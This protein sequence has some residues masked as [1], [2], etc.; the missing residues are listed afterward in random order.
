MRA[1]HRVV[2][3]HETIEIDPSIALTYVKLKKPGCHG[4]QVLLNG[5]CVFIDIKRSGTQATLLRYNAFD[6]DVSGAVSFMWDDCFFCLPTGR[7]DGEIFA[8]CGCGCSCNCEHEKLATVSFTKRRTRARIDQTRNVS[9]AEQ[10]SPAC[11]PK[12]CCDGA[13]PSSM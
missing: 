11:P 2:T 6:L 8:D 13:V 7:Y 10:C 3:R 5:K 1:A 12:E 4:E 9:A